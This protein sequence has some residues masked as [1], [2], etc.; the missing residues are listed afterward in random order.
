MYL[1]DISDFENVS[2]YLPILNGALITD[3]IVMSLSLSGYINSEALK[4]WYKSYG[5]S[6]VLADV[7]IL[8]IGLII[9]RWLYNMFF[10]SRS[11]FSFILVALGVQLTHDLVFGKIIDFMPE[12][13]S[14]IFN[15]F[16][17]YTHE[18]GMQILFAD[19][20]MIIST[21]IL[22]SLMAAYD[23]NMNIITIIFMA[24]HVPYLIHSF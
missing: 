19:S 9:A 4:I 6:A 17:Q 7:L 1:R 2:D 16:K 10:K 15:T 23:L 20:L 8:V 3:V 22:G 18:H 11:L 21:I 5:L 14:N 12:K 13:T 24:Y